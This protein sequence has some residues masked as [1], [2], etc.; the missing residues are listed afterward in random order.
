MA[1]WP[2]GCARVRDLAEQIRNSRVADQIG[3]AL[4]ARV[5]QFQCL[6]HVVLFNQQSQ[7]Y[8]G[9]WWMRQRVVQQFLGPF[10][11]VEGDQVAAGRDAGQVRGRTGNDIPHRGPLVIHIEPQ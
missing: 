2:I 7:R 3:V 6:E 10:V 1:S 5:F 9:P 8:G 11:A 4:A